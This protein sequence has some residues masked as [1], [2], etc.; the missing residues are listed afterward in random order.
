MFKDENAER[1]EKSIPDGAWIR[2]SRLLCQTFAT[3]VFS[4]V[5][6]CWEIQLREKF[7]ITN[8][9]KKKKQTNSE[10]ALLNWQ[11]VFLDFLI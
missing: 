10:M 9:G 1:V 8:M 4:Q 11:T 2:I 7:C 6:H 5:L 3:S